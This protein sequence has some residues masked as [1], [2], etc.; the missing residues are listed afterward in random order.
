MKK[1]FVSAND[2]LTAKLVEEAGFDGIWVSGFEV[3]SSLLLVDNG[4]ITH[5]ELVNVT[6]TITDATKLPVVVDCDSGGSIHQAIR[7]AKELVKVGAWGMC[8]EDNPLNKTN[9][10]WEAKTVLASKEEHGAKIK[11]IK[12]YAPGIKVIA[13]TEALIRH[14]GM[15]EAL[16]RAEYYVDCGADLVVIHSRETTGKEALSIPGYWKLKVPLVCIPTKFPHINNNE[17][18]DAGFSMS[19]WANQVL[20]TKILAV[21]NMLKELKKTDSAVNI[22]KSFSVSLDDLRSLTPV[23]EAESIDKEFGL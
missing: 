7:L 2:A 17:L 22:E 13:R 23:K 9:S 21:R 1:V 14:L 6:K 20:R 4:V 5:T 11:A 10:L 15:A 12:K 3:S 18:F 16:L 8:I 19:I